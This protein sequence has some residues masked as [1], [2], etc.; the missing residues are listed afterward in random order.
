[1]S[2]NEFCIV[3][4]SVLFTLP[5]E[6]FFISSIQTLGDIHIANFSQ[7]S[8]ERL[9]EKKTK[10]WEQIFLRICVEKLPQGVCFCFF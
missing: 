10:K 1:M 5:L 3:T 6:N 7:I 4:H 9:V 2:E 8:R